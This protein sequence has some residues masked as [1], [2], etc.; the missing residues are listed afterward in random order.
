MSD[1]DLAGKVAVV[2]GA[3]G[4]IGQ[5]ICH[6]LAAAGAALVVHGHRQVETAEQLVL[7]LRQAGAGAIRLCGDL[8]KPAAATQVIDATV[9]AFGG[10]DLLINNAGVT[11]G[12]IGV[13][14]ISTE[15]WLAVTDINLH[16]VFYLCRAAIPALRNRGGGS[17]VN[18]A[19]NIV[20]SLP[21]GSA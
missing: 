20:N 1:R 5:A 19:S 14:E 12:G 10:I 11:L 16:S 17:I 9:E 2:T 18:V 6:E 3:T 15:D 4:G 21:G 13:E 8:T 7:E